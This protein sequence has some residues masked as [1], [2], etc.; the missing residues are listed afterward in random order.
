MRFSEYYR[1]TKDGK[2]LLGERI[3][4][5]Y[6]RSGRDRDRRDD[7]DRRGG[8]DDRRPYER[9][10]PR[11]PRPRRTGFRAIVENLSPSVSWQV[12]VS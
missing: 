1:L 12:S 6:S 10:E 3:S 4:V 5:E 9:R 11:F 8:Y 7:Y 2:A